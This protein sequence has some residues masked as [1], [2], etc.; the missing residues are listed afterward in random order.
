MCIKMHSHVIMVMG[1]NMIL[2][3]FGDRIKYLREK[4]NIPQ[5]KLAQTTGIVRE[6]ISRIENGQIN[7]TLETVYKLSEALN[8]TMTELFDYDVVGSKYNITKLELKPFVK[9][10][11]G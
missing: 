11:G 8:I 9:W 5:S 6:Q 2:T 10:A 7:Q 1:D 3:T 4:Q